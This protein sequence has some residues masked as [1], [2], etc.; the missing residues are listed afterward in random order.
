M[1]D[2]RIDVAK[3]DA[4]GAASLPDAA[5]SSC[6]RYELGDRGRDA[7]G[8]RRRAR[9]ARSRTRRR[10]RARRRGLELDVRRDLREGAPRALLRD[11]HRRAADGRRGGRPAG[12][13]LEA[14]RL[15]VRGVLHARLRLRPHGG[16]QPRD[17]S[18]SAGS[19]AGVSIGEDGPSQMGLE[20]IAAFRAVHGERR[21][22]PVRREP[23]GE[24]RR[25]DGRRR[26]GSRTCGR[27]GPRRR[28][29]TG[30]TRSSRSAAPRAA[31][32]ATSDEVDD[33]RR[34]GSRCTR[35]WRRPTCSRRTGSRRA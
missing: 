6:P 28:S 7:Q 35:R 29:S 25:G 16:G 27:S 14:V 32:V 9:R 21:A 17:A 4:G 11:V 30:P 22:A 2:I 1:R 20:D 31:L 5:S 13:R 24:A 26:T 18:R 34:P 33:R 8:L 3:P 10:R 19:H 12:R 23:D 15:D